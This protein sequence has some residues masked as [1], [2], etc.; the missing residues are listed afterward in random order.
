MSS[1]DDCL[2][3]T[4]LPIRNL[5]A[6]KI[7]ANLTPAQVEYVTYLALVSEASF[8]IIFVQTSR[9]SPMI[10]D[11]LSSFVSVYPIS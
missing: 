8:P 1:E 7:L 9:Q 6:D 2:A 4:G 11:F 3:S 10:H 5:R